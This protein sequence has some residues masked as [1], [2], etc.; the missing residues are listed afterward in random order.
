MIPLSE[1]SLSKNEW[2]YVKQC[3]DSGWVSSAGPFIGRFETTVRN[4][5]STSHA[6]AVVSGTAALHLSLR[7]AGVSL[8]D[9]VLVPTLSFIAPA[10]AIRY[11]GAHPIFF[12]C[13]KKTLCLDVNSVRSFLYDECTRA[14]DGSIRNKKSGR[15]IAAVIAVHIFGHPVDMDPL[16]DICRD[17]NLSCIE[18]ACESLG[19]KYKGRYT[20]TLGDIGCFSFN[21][22][23]IVTTGGGGVIVTNRADWARL[24]RHLS[25]Q[26]KKDGIEYDHDDIGYNYRMTSIQAALGVAQMERLNRFIIVKRKNAELYNSLLSTLNDIEFVGEESWAECNRWFYTIR[27][28]RDVKERLLMHLIKNEIQV[29]PVWK[30][31]HTLPMYHDCCTYT[32]LEV[33]RGAYDECINLPCSVSLTE[34]NIET[35]TGAIRTF[36]STT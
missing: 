3:L 17:L 25:T 10:N 28:P 29:R 24:A 23:K 21:G 1:P 31:I 4:Y 8:D 34:E 12:D 35:V 14:N 13:D 15:R 22:N 9:E 16:K 2:L 27:V 30:L 32:T 36:F 5:I 7:I 11:C 19:S 33:A 18:D 20:G 6:V 26:A